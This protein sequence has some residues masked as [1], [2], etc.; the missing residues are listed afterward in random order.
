[1][2]ALFCL[3]PTLHEKSGSST[4]MATL[5]VLSLFNNSYSSISVV[6]LCI[7]FVW[8][9]FKLCFLFYF[10]F[11]LVE[12]WA[13]L[14]FSWYRI[15][16]QC[17]RPEFDLWVGKIPWRRERLP[18]PIFWP[19]KFHGLYNPWDCKG[20]DTT[21]RPSHTLTQIVDLQCCSFWY[22]AKWFSLTHKVWHTHMHI[23][24]Y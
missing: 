22:T 10:I 17:R 16:L 2:I 24:L 13:S 9:I 11:F 3:S 19:G 5:E 12:V 8:I 7:L 14:W 23:Y 18:T 20:L 15:P 4:C 6:T 1:M 21:E